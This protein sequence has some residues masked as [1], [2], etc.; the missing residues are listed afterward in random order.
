M[1]LKKSAYHLLSID[2]A[3]GST[4]ITLDSVPTG[5]AKGDI[6]AITAT[7][8]R[9]KKNTDPMFQTE[10]ELRRINAI[11][12][13]S[14]ILGALIDPNTLGPLTHSHIPSIKKMPVYAANLTRNVVF[15]S[16]G[17]NLVPVN[18]RGHFVVMHNPDAVIK[19]AGFYSFGRTNKSIPIDDFLLDAHG[20]RK[21]DANGNYIPGPS[22]NPRGRYAVHFHHTGVA[23]INTTPVICS[24]NA[25]MFS[26]GWGFVN[27]TSHVIMENNASFNVY[28]SH[29]VSEDGN[30][31][32]AYKHNI[33]IKSEGRDTSAKVGFGNHDHGHTGHGF[34][35][36]SRNMLVEDNVVSGVNSSGLVYYQRN[37]NPSIDLDIPIQNL[38]TSNKQIAKGFPTIKHAN[39]P[40]TRQKDMTVLSSGSVLNVIKAT[41]GQGHDVRNMFES[42]RGYS[43]PNGM[44]LQYTDK[45]TFKNLEIIADPSTNKWAHGVNIAINDSDVVFINS[46]VDGF[47]HPFFTGRTF[48]DG[49]QKTDAVFVN[50]LVDGKPIN[51]E[52][53]IQL[54]SA[55]SI[56]N[57]DPVI[58]HILNIPENS[59][60]GLLSTI[61]DS[62]KF[63]RSN[64]QTQTLPENLGVGITVSG[65]KTDSLGEIAFESKWSSLLPLIKKGYYINSNGDKFLVLT[66]MIA[67]RMSGE[68]KPI[69]TRVKLVQF[70]PSLGPLLGQLVN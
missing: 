9:P 34:W 16:E 22:N 17:G 57:F 47:I 37:I 48:N 24:G 59:M 68:T 8:F 61:R 41:L 3:A 51:P 65:T 40:I 10:D 54:I 26:P 49:I 5:W 30:E 69:F 55:E 11:S 52:T 32:G 2:P 28:G 67:D 66:D 56:S 7:K 1:A 13:N 43:V 36:H 14:I 42:L 6:I 64:A 18:Q 53:D 62:L 63:T 38:L 50:V 4:Q 12:G 39:I 60:T 45:Y 25:V 35:L 19:G 70:Y 29:F 21:T 44:H 23:N 58:H 46:R 31:L 33:A 15:K 27:H 20:F